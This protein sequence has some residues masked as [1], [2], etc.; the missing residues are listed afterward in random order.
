M[1][2]TQL[3]KLAYVLS[4]FF[5]LK[6]TSITI[7]ILKVKCTAKVDVFCARE[8]SHFYHLNFRDMDIFAPHATYLC[9]Y[10]IIMMLI[11]YNI[12]EWKFIN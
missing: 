5:V 3:A 6:P 9:Q 1:R 10:N 8:Y 2:E 4:F 12:L 7:Y 11:Y